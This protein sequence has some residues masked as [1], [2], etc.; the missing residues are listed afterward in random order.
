MSQLTALLDIPPS[1]VYAIMREESGFNPKAVSWAGAH[2]L[3][4]L[5]VKTGASLARADGVKRPRRITGEHLLDAGRLA[6]PDVTAVA[7][8]PFTRVLRKGKTYR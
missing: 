5:M 4:Q 7:Q 1:L 8:L 6:E 2:G 3:L